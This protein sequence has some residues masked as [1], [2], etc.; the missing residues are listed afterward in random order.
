M[1]ACINAAQSDSVDDLMDFND[2][3]IIDAMNVKEPVRE[4]RMA[5]NLPKFNLFPYNCAKNS[6]CSACAEK[7]MNG[8][9]YS[10]LMDT[11]GGFKS[12]SSVSTEQ[13]LLPPDIF[14]CTHNSRSICVRMYFV[15]TYTETTTQSLS[16]QE[17]QDYSLASNACMN[18]DIP[19]R[20]CHWIPFSLIG[21]KECEDCP[22]ICR[23]IRQT[24]SFPQFIL[25]MTLLVATNPL[26]FFPMMAIISNQ[27]PPESQVGPCV[28]PQ[29]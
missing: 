19:H 5:K 4:L 23:S 3:M 8:S 20:Q 13:A 2:L 21:H 12:L 10:F 25:G 15:H 28:V 6:S 27:T 9:C 22:P 14:S 1:S 11:D 17:N 26:I 16:F 7:D 29:M 24:L 18:A